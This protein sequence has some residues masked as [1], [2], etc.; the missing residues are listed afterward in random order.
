MTRPF[1]IPIPGFR[2]DE[3]GSTGRSV[4]ATET[5]LAAR[6]A[7]GLGAADSPTFAGLTVPDGTFALPKL[8]TQPAATLL[9]NNSGSNASPSALGV[10][11]A[12]TLLGLATTDSPTFAGGT[13]NGQMHVG[14]TAPTQ[15]FSYLMS[16]GDSHFERGGLTWASN[17]LV[18]SCGFSGTGV[19]RDT[20]IRS[21]R[22]ITSPAGGIL[23][24]M[25][26]FSAGNRAV[27]FGF[28]LAVGGSIAAVNI[29]SNSFLG[30]SD[31]LAT[32]GSTTRLY[33]NVPNTIRQ[34]NGTAGQRHQWF[35]TYTS[36]TN[37]E[38]F[39][40]DAAANA[41]SIDLA[42][43]SGSAG[44]NSREI[45]I[46]S[47][48][49]GAANLTPWLTFGT[50]GIAT[51]GNELRF[52]SSGVRLIRN[53][54]NLEI[55]SDN[56]SSST[57]IIVGGSSVVSFAMEAATFRGTLN[58]RAS[59]TAAGTAPIK[60][61]TGVLMTTPE[62]GAIE[63]DGTNLYFT[64]SG[65]TRNKLREIGT[66]AFSEYESGVTHVYHG[67]TDSN[68]NWAIYRYDNTTVVRTIANQI[69]NIGTTTLASAWTNRATL[70]YS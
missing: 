32:S 67:G 16:N 45:R 20:E 33:G 17:R 15:I 28:N 31:G 24:E 64:D 6:D 35:K 29:A 56:A 1:V 66:I 34:F 52:T 43:L 63:Y 49:A 61:A 70:T 51:L 26:Y 44:G 19:Q 37:F 68:G 14:R 62:A 41:T 9:G 42:I 54:N 2:P 47:K 7:I 13:F 11:D 50:N 65:G 46:G 58:A 55:R 25:D 39:E 40:I 69:N 5:Q 18:L 8:A 60:L 22:F 27:V 30:F 21:C 12:R 3:V 23:L 36:D 48:Y 10:S 57:S 4:V 53:V 59:T 38:A